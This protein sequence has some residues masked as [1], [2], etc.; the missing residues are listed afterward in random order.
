MREVRTLTNALEWGT[1]DRTEVTLGH[2]EESA[3]I[4]LPPVGSSVYF[5]GENQH[6][7]K[8]CVY[9]TYL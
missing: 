8:E 5:M 1:S 2:L 3:S 4:L 7:V 9:L 6:R